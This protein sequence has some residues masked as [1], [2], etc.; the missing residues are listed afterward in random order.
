MLRC[1][2]IPLRVSRE[3]LGFNARE[4]AEMAQEKLIVCLANSRKKSG[5]CIA[6]IEYVGGRRVGWIRPVSSRHGGEVSEDERNYENGSDP[7]VLDQIAL[8]LLE[9]KPTGYQVENYLLDP[10]RYWVRQGRIGWAQL[11]RLEDEPRALWLSNDCSTYNGMN[12]RV[13]HEVANG[14]GDSLRL[15][16]VDDLI[17]RVFAPRRG[18]GDGTRRVQG[19][20]TYLST[21]YRLRITDPAIEAEYLGGDDGLYE[22]G[23]SYLTMSLGE[24]FDGYCY[25]LIAAV[26]DRRRA[27]EGV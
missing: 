8:S 13:T 21:E 20:F 14:L 17:L 26:I 23:E 19:C 25:K 12:D 18:F 1:P 16:H 4:G 10:E 9:P 22:R 2:P 7:Q 15:I 5:R 24:P 27:G 6:G 3:S 11:S